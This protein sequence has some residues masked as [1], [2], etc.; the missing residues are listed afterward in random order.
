[1]SA[2]T[3]S[4]ASGTLAPGASRTVSGTVR[5][6]ARIAGL[7]RNTVIATASN[8]PAVT[9]VAGHPGSSA[10]EEGRASG[11]GRRDYPRP[12]PWPWRSPP[13]TTIALPPPRRT[14]SAA[15]S[16]VPSPRNSIPVAAPISAGA[17]K[18]WPR[19]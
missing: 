11:V 9:D 14:G 3:R 10:G 12:S 5:I 4:G 2:A 8:A 13:L 19:A 17:L 18:T 16:T 6:T 15:A 7:R 1:M